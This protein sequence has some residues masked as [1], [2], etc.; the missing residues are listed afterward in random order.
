MAKRPQDTVFMVVQR[1][2]PDGRVSLYRRFGEGAAEQ[3]EKLI[4][5]SAGQLAWTG[6]TNADVKPALLYGLQGSA[7]PLTRAEDPQKTESDG[8]Q[9]MWD[10]ALGRSDTRLPEA[11]APTAAKPSPAK[12]C[13]IPDPGGAVA[14]SG[15]PAADPAT[16]DAWS[17]YLGH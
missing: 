7:E 3:T 15:A 16:Q 8:I 9:A 2:H 17:S 6:V 14:G 10:R 11:A 4:A 5:D 12:Q 13:F 1:T